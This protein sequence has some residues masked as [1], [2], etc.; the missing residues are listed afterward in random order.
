MEV[1]TCPHCGAMVRRGNFCTR[2]GGKLVEVCDCWVKKKAYNCGRAECP[3]IHLHQL[4]IEDLCGTRIFKEKDFLRMKLFS[5]KAEENPKSTEQDL[6]AIRYLLEAYRTEQ[7]DEDRCLRRT[8]YT[9][10]ANRRLDWKILLLVCGAGGFVGVC[11]FVILMQLLG[12]IPVGIPA[13]Q[14]MGF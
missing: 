10:Q 2:C 8:I 4:E 12:V 14:L 9:M 11:V 13:E 7:T 5:P 3:G 1:V 6:R